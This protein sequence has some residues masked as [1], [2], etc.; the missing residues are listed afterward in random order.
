MAID[1]QVCFHEW[2]FA[3]V[4]RPCNY[5][6]ITGPVEPVY[7][8]NKDMCGTKLCPVTV[9]AYPVDCDCFCHL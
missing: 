4:F 2:L 1:I 8:I 9:S 3:N 7:G 6:G 5:K